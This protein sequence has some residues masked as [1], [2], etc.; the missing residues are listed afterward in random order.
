MPSYYRDK[1]LLVSGVELCGFHVSSSA[2]ELTQVSGVPCGAF[3]GSG[4]GTFWM[5][6][7]RT[8]EAVAFL[9]F[10]RTRTGRDVNEGVHFFTE[11]TETADISDKT[12]LHEL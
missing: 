4:C 5:S 11:S 12:P 3:H 8:D 10:H 2:D 6:I 9:T 1:L 7:S